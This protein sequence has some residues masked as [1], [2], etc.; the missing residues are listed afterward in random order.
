MNDVTKILLVDDEEDFCFFVKAHLEKGGNYQVRTLN[1]GSKALGEAQNFQPDLIFLDL[2]MQDK[3]GDEVYEE[4]KEDPST[5]DIPIIFL[6]ALASGMS[7]QQATPVQKVG[8]KCFVAKPVGKVR[9]LQAIH[10][11]L[12]GT[13]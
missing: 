13:V 11:V 5:R 10:S 12:D 3:S 2:V 8:G 7:D 1:Q 9:L 4:L 6:T